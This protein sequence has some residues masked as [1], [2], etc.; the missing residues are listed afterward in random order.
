[1]DLA[2]LR[3][4]E[5]LSGAAALALLVTLFLDWNRDSGAGRA[6]TRVAGAGTQSGWSSLGVVMLALVLITIA[7]ALAL[8]SA[9]AGKRPAAIPI[10]AAVLTTGAGVVVTLVLALR[11]L[12]LDD[13]LGGAYLGLLF[14]GLIPVGGWIAMADERTDAPYS[15]AP[16]LPRR[17]APPAEA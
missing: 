2:R 7:L 16:D 14:M 3:L 4:G 6:A 15:A 5:L 11:V 17:P 10:G 8:V 12:F 1:M 13:S 9:T